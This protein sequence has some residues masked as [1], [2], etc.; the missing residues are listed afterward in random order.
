VFQAPPWRR[1]FAQWDLSTF[2]ANPAEA[3]LPV[4]FNNSKRSASSIQSGSVE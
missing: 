4:R 3:L 1:R 2:N